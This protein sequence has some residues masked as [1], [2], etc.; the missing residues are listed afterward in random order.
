MKVRSQWNYTNN[1][2]GWSTD[3]PSM[4]L[5]DESLTLRELANRYSRGTIGSVMLN[6]KYDDDEAPF[7][8][9]LT[10]DRLNLSDPV[11]M[12]EQMSTVNNYVENVLSEANTKLS[13]ANNKKNNATTINDDAMKSNEASP[14][15][16]DLSA[17]DDSKT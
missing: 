5:P 6:G 15:V 4:C 9:P 3:L 13:K 17:K 8:A 12:Q 14:Q 1:S 2:P 10:P 11:D 16:V 7:D